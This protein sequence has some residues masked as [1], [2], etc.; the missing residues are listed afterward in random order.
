MEGN[1]KNSAHYTV[2]LY[3]AEA[4]NNGYI[5]N[6]EI[7]SVDKSLIKIKAFVNDIQK[8]RP[9]IMMIEANMYTKRDMLVRSIECFENK[10]VINTF[11]N[12]TYII[13][14]CTK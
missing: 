11:Q 6:V 13:V 5:D 9:V 2:A 8:V 4:L 10:L 12:I 7:S 14:V 3:I 1:T